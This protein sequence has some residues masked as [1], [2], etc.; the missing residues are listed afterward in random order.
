MIETHINT[1]LINQVHNIL[2][3]VQNTHLVIREIHLHFNKS[4]SNTSSKAYLGQINK[5]S[6]FFIPLLDS[7]QAYVITNLN[8]LVSS[9]DPRSLERC[10]KRIY[11]HGKT[12]YSD[13]LRKLRADNAD[14]LSVIT[15]YRMNTFAHLG[16]IKEDSANSISEKQYI[17]LF[18]DVKIFA[19]KLAS[20]YDLILHFESD[21]ESDSIAHT[22]QLLQALLRS[23]LKESDQDS[24]LNI[25][26]LYLEGRKKWFD[27]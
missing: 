13:D 3:R 19:T 26:S 25:E 8:R 15:N 17:K 21:E 1:I 16:T 5:F 14:I 11:S 12:D 24:A 2:Y 10:V 18:C 7:G 23:D 22:H 20:E 27:Q 6:N 4:I 9:N